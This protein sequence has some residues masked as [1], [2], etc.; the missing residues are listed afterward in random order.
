MSELRQDRTSGAWVLVAPGR[1]R[2]PHQEGPPAAAPERRPAFDPA[3]PFCPG[4]E[5]L[6][7]AII[8]EAPAG[9]APGWLTRVV[10]N[11]YPA[12]RPEGGPAQAA[13]RDGAVMA[14]YGHHEVIIETAR[15]DADL[16]TLA[17]A[18]MV[19]VIRACR[20]R[21]LALMAEP[22]ICSVLVFRNHGPRGGAS[23]A[24]PHSQVIATA[25]TPPKLAAARAWA[26]AD[27]TR[28]GRCPICEEIARELASAVRVVEATARFIVL[29]PFAAAAPFE[30]W[31]LP[32]EH[33]A[34]LAGHDESALAELAGLLQRT[35]ARL[36]TALDDPPYNYAIEP[37]SAEADDA[38]CAHWRLRIVPRLVAPGGFELGSGLPI[39]PSCPEE[40]AEALRAATASP[41][42]R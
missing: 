27:P 2:R 36:G 8:D 35:L 20:D 26:H 40:D 32:R 14:G 13:G 16:A 25:M 28:R 24:H 22:A 31:I 7:P 19:A 18:D 39:N 42:A 21:C 11:K 37:G 23:L 5:H 1:G 34:S 38:S 12:L 29:V 30:Q 10:P 4:N 6:L 41:D 3:C 33:L 15:H 17:D 9:H